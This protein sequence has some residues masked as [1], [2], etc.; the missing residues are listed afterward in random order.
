MSLLIAKASTVFL[1]WYLC[2]LRSALRGGR[3]AHHVSTPD[4]IITLMVVIEI[5]DYEVHTRLCLF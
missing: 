1:L 5:N 2:Y 4:G 3:A